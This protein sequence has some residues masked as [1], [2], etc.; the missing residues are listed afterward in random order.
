[1]VF[2]TSDCTI[3]PLIRPS[4]PTI[5]FLLLVFCR[6]QLPKAAL[7]LTVSRGDKVSPGLPPMVPLM[8]EMLLINATFLFFLN[9]QT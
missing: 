3:S 9:A 4:R 8:P 2:T 7:N 1:M 5:I 6:S